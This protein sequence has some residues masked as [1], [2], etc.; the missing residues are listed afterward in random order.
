MP[1][2]TYATFRPVS[3][4]EIRPEGWLR[5]YLMRQCEGLTAHPEA[6]GYPYGNRFWGNL[7]P[8]FRRDI[9]VWWP[10]EQ[11][12]YWVEGALKG[13]YLIGDQQVYQTALREVDDAVSHAAPDGF[14]GPDFLREKDRWPYAVFFRAVLAQY[15][16]SGD[17]SYID[18]LVKHYKSSPQP[19]DW[20]RDVTG[21]EILV[22][23]YWIT[24]DED[25]LEMADDLYRRFNVRFSEH[26]C[27]LQSMTSDKRATEHGVSYN[28]IGKLAAIL[29][30][31]NGQEA[32]LQAATN[33]FA[34]VDRDQLLADGLHSCTEQLRGKDALDSHETCDITDH[35]W[36]LSYLLQANGD[37]AYADRIEKIM[38][39]AAPGAITKDFRALQYFSCPNQIVA[40]ANTNHNHFMSGDNW[41]M[42]RPDHEIQCCPGNVHRAMPNFVHRMWLRAP[43]QTPS[44]GIAAAMYGPGTFS[45]RAGLQDK[46]IFI[47]CETNYPFEQEVNFELET[48]EPNTFGWLLRIPGWCSQPGLWVNEQAVRQPLHPGSFVR[49]DREWQAGDRI[50]LSLPF[51]LSVEKWPN[52]GI[53]LNY[54]PITLSLPVHARAEEET[55]NSTELQRR[56]A[57]KDTYVPPTGEP[58]EGFPAWNLYPES[59]WNY[60]L[61]VD[62]NSLDQTAQVTWKPSSRYAFDPESVPFTVRVPARRVRGWQLSHR[63]SIFRFT[64]WFEDGELQRG[65]R[66][67]RGDFLFTPPLPN[68]AQLS[69]RLHKTVEWIDLVPY[70]STLLRMTVFPQ[71]NL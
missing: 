5:T 21:V 24:G 37:A 40:G 17:R 4:E 26:D 27:S 1:G 25:L 59:R 9:D 31:A 33:G 67:A 46:P 34:K 54:G 50:R 30:C 53:S 62:E 45:S 36:A 19:L 6:S 15:E 49:I 16:I 38:F 44:G 13:G 57:L 42:Y 69:A 12:G 41:M 28:E 23:L 2:I 63:K 56:K 43:D 61:C 47:R 22:L 32:Y 48:E 58:P 52:G 11:T 66:Q 64:H 51:H 65:D 10:Y 60:A 20:D 18:A 14:I 7:D 68:P 35:T 71:A 3:L 29:Y 55:E 39:N 8:D 70:G